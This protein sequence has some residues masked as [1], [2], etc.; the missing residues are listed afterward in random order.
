MRVRDYK[1]PDVL[2]EMTAFHAADDNEQAG[3]EHQQGEFG[4]GEGLFHIE[5]V[6]DD[7]Q[8]G[9]TQGGHE[10][11][12]PMQCAMRHESDNHDDEYSQCAVP[13]ARVDELIAILQ[14][15]RFRLFRQ[16]LA[17]QVTQEEQDHQ[18]GHK[19]HEEHVLGEFVEA[20][21]EF[22]ADHDVRRVADQRRH[23]TGIGQ[24]RRGQQK[25]NGVDAH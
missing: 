7:G 11:G 22:R 21:I 6:A 16:F 12:F 14:V 15:K 17:E 10:P 5:F 9:E 8:A 20:D 18:P 19:H 3:E 23:A 2:Q 25:G 4:T 1:L 24:Q 13:G